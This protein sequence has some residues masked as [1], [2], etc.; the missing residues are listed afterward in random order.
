MKQIGISENIDAQDT[1]AANG[2]DAD[3]SWVVG[4]FTIKKLKI[5]IPDGF[6]G[7]GIFEG[8]ISLGIRFGAV[9]FGNLRYSRPNLLLIA[10]ASS[11]STV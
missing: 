10:A 7:T 2:D 4:D 9:G 11:N 6:L 3:N 5:S 1:V 8:R